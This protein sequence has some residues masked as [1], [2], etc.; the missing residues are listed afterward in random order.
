MQI[1]IFTI[2]ILD[3]SRDMEMMNRFLRGHRV[4]EV[5]QELVKTDGGG[6]WCFCIRYLEGGNLPIT[7][8][9]KEKVDYKEILDEKTFDIFSLLRIYRKEIAE[10]EGVPVYA[11]FTNAELAKIA[12]LPELLP[13]QMKT[14]KGIGSNKL[15]KYGKPILE[16]FHLKQKNE[17]S[18]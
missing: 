16:M 11:V 9:R 13:E 10:K 7:G 14:I 3:S 6:Y 4:L 12:E 2:P 5:K 15:E 18:G 1:Q 17:K 8:S